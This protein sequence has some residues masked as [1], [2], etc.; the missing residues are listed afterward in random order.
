VNLGAGT[1]LS[2]FRHDGAEVRIPFGGRLISTGRRK[3]GALLGDG[4][5][6]GC[7]SVLNPGTIVGARTQIYTG[8]QLRSGVWPA[9]SIVKLRQSLEVVSL[10][11]ETRA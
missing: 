3:L 2:N 11:R 8:A 1:V 10:E 7:N 5:A 6:T 4:V 9:D